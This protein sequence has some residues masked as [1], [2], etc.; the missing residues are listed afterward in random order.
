MALSAPLY[1]SHG[2]E[3]GTIDLVETFFGRAVNT[4]LIH[5]LLILQHAN[6]RLALAHTK[7][8][9]ERRGSTRKLYRQKGTGNARSGAS[10]SPVRKKG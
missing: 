8:R 10:R 5:R 9:G 2:T 6:A 1:D 7:T 4:G 3:I